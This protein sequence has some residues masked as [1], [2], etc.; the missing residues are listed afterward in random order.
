MPTLRVTVKGFVQGVGFRAYVAGL[1]RSLGVCGEVWNQRDGSVGAILQ[2]P[3]QEVLRMLVERLW[4][5][6]GKV[7]A[8]EAEGVDLPTFRDF[9]IGM[10]R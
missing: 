5:G 2:H 9:Q 4:E 10:T 7:D 8:V 3:D 1:A 6:P